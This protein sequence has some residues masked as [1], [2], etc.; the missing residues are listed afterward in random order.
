MRVLLALLLVGIAGCGGEDNSSDDVAV[1][2]SP[3][4]TQPAVADPVAAL[5][6]L[7]AEIER[8][9]QGENVAV[10]LYDT[11]ITDAGLVH[12]KGMT[13]LQVLGLPEQFT[14]AGMVH[15]KGLT[16]L[17]ALVLG[18]TKITDA[19]LVHIKGLTQLQ[20]L[21]LQQTKVTDA[22]VA[23]LQKALPNCEIEK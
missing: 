2:P 20:D 14:D 9:A 7:G 6:K 16:K 1:P 11:K 13:N 5:K 15:L 23:D 18:G 19:G 8:N 17:E 4:V 21:G 12:L 10:Y 22:G 3:A